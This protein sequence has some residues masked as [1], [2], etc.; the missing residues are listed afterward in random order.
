MLNILSLHIPLEIFSTFICWSFEVSAIN[1]ETFLVS[2][3]VSL[4]THQFAVFM[5]IMIFYSMPKFDK[6]VS[7]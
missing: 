7:G 4:F 6:A 3:V 5:H 1:L 2:A